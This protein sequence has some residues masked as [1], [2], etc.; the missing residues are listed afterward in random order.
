M[1]ELFFAVSGSEDV[2]HDFKSD[3]MDYLQN[4]L[5][6]DVA[7]ETEIVPCAGPKGIRFL[8]TLVRRRVKDSPAVR[9]VHKLKEKVQ[10]FALQ[11][12]EAWDVGTFIIGKKWLAH[13]FRKVKESQIKYLAD[14][15]CLLS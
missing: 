4:V 2:A 9:A 10:A 5:M 12:Q 14:S 6:L 11:K 3:I 1:D 8:G 7:S 15:N 13:G